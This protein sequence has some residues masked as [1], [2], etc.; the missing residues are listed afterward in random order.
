M[1]NGSLSLAPQFEDAAQQRAAAS[2]GIW[3]FLATEV[4]F[5]GVLFA[6]YTITRVRHP[7]AFAAASRL[8]VISLASIN[9]AV[10]LTSSLTMALAVHAAKRGAQRAL[11][12]W[13][14][15][16]ICLGLAFLAI[17]GAEYRVDFAEHLVPTLDFAY[18]G[19][20]ADNVEVFFYLYFLITG[21]HALHVLI[22]VLAISAIAF[23]A[24]RGDFGPA[25][26]TP[27]DVTGLYWHLVDIIWL[28]VYPC[29][30]LVNRS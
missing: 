20:Q 12:G 11:K 28:F 15:L 4:L 8:T 19:A 29:L 23:M 25:Y 30:Y 1:A 14:A 9:T 16:T 17:K 24:R 6:A 5:F 2:L 13:L 26:Y 10:L 3:V 21:V 7:E 18:A 22:G 27:V